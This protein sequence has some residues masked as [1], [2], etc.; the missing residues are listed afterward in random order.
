MGSELGVRPD[1]KPEP[2][3]S[4]VSIWWA[5][6]AGVWTL[7]VASGMAYL[8]S[9]RNM[10]ILRMRGLSLSL[11]AV[12]LL[13]LYYVPVQFGTMIGPIVPG[14]AQFWIMGTF[15]PCGIALFHAS[16]S[17]F[18]HVAKLQRKYVYNDSR[19][20]EIPP[21]R[22][23][24][25]LL[26]RFQRLEY[27]TRIL[28]LV[29][30]GMIAQ[31]LL[32]VV[33]WLTSRKWHPTW[34][35]PGTE[36]HGAKMAQL[37]AMG[38]GYE[39]WPSIFWQ[40]FWAW[41]F[42]PIVLWKSRNIRDTYSWRVQTIGCA[43]A[44]LPGAPLWLISIYVP[45][46]DKVNE[47]W[48]PPQWICLSILVMEIFT[49]FLPCWEVMRHQALR[50]ETLDCI[51]QWEAK[52]KTS[53]SATKSLA[54][55]GTLVE[56]IL[57]GAKSTN[58]SVETN[59]SRESILTMGALEYVLQRDPAP[60]QRFS[61][62]NDFSGE[63]I[64]FLTSVAE[65]KNTFP[66][67]IRENDAS[68]DCNTEDLVRE[69]FNRALHIYA[70]FI[71]IAHAEFPVNISSQDLRKLRDIFDLPARMLYGEEREVVDPATPFDSFKP[72]A[73]PT[74]SESSQK[75]LQSSV[76]AIHDR[77]QYWGDVPEGFG[78]AI[79]DDAEESIKYLVLTNTWP[80]FIKN[81]TAS[82]DASN[83]LHAGERV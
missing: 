29:G 5:T 56:S 57:A 49:V 83:R 32:T 19:L 26:G 55:T 62:L 81:R 35:I 16:N 50:Q 30:I 10:P 2:I 58:G 23:K 48:L 7:A 44:N 45:A 78:P 63:N 6:W 72:P 61:A 34:G 25:G 11:S 20:I 41:I 8:I 1:S 65:W 37:S 59:S 74:F 28:I 39:W 79:F 51:A 13:H 12:V 73:S 36:V 14:D 9:R 3:Y 17:R 64:A 77:V 71:S 43:I 47:V 54:S 40:L 70:E 80:K 15:L 52:N 24:G 68:Q 18:L 27:D 75:E 60:L 82:I 46:F 38:R 31:I 42:A 76:A 66:R 22:K 67:A 53:S 69:R 4:P 21:N 33:M